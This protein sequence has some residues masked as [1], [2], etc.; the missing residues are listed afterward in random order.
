MCFHDSVLV[1]PTRKPHHIRS[2]SDVQQLMPSP[3]VSIV[4]ELEEDKYARN[5]DILATSTS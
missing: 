3:L 1:H 5:L 2:P 4:E